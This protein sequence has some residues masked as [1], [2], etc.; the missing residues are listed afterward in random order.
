MTD[1]SGKPRG[2]IRWG[3]PASILVHVVFV[4]A[5][6]FHL[7]VDQSEPEKEETVQV[8]IVP[9]PEEPEKKPEEQKPEEKK[10]EEAKPEE[11]KP[12]EPAKQE[13]AKTV[14]PP[15]PPE[16]PK[17]EEAKKQ[18]PPP[19]PPP[20]PEEK[21]AEPPPSA[22]QAKGQ[23]LPVLRPVF[24]F[25]E[26]DGGPKKSET[27]NASKET[28]NPPAESKADAEAVEPVKQAKEAPTVVEAPPANPVPDDI[29][30]PEV[31]VAA[32]NGLQNGP[33]AGT[34]PD[35]AKTEIV[36]AP[37]AASPKGDPSKTPTAGKLVELTEAKT[38]FSQSETDDPIAT[39]TI[40]RT[41][42]G[43]RAGQLCA[44]E[45]SFQLWH[46]SPPYPA[47]LVRPYRL[48]S[49]S[50]LEVKRSE[51]RAKAQWYELSFRCEVNEDATKVISFAFE[52]GK[53]VPRSEWR[54]RGFPE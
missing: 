4:A 6:F 28:T 30:L 11:K 34:S 31:G 29:Q 50:V 22:D 43:V 46:A 21:P 33:V 25:G 38:L 48:P 40:G 10:V 8:E 26:K 54:K 53:L 35:A 27:G 3:I 18:E 47:D 39:T 9:P 45:L 20:A 17:Q 7:P 32:A 2:D 42:R 14:E 1:L 44:T 37:P 12:P 49:G 41:P 51:F 13:E 24:E 36:T 5:L 15:P 16:P 52:V 19:P 23:P